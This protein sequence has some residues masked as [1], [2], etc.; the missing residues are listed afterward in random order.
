[1]YYNIDELNQL[2]TSIEN[3]SNE[4]F[5]EIFEY[6]DGLD[7]YLA[8]SNLNSR[9][10]QLVTSSSIRFKINLDYETSKEIFLTNYNQIKQQ[11][12]SI[13][14]QLPININQL[15]PSFTI[16]SS[17]NRLESIVIED[18]LPDK[19]ILFLSHLADLPRLFS[20]NIKTIHIIEDLNNIY[21]LIFALPT[22]KYNKLYLY[23]NECSISIP[24]NNNK[25]LS[26]IEYLDI[27]HWYTFD[28]LSALISYTPQLRRLSLSHI[29]QDDSNTETMLPVTLNN[30]TYFSM[31]TNNINFDEFEMFIENI[32]SKLKVL[33]VSFSYKDITLLHA[34]RWEQLISRYFPQLEKFSLRYREGGG[35]R[36]EYPIYSGGQ[37][38]FISP[39][40]IERKWLLEIDTYEYSINYIVRPYRYF[41][42]DC[43]IC[44][45]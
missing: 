26:T 23:G 13:N 4:L 9:F 45:E 31:H 22:L 36:D 24:M 43:F 25:Q 28:E 21:Q 32:Y 3:F 15:L 38:Q 7:I 29:N 20:L 37:N 14:F 5:Y 2:L 44:I 10:E 1:L 41:G 16:D 11:I 27:A 33:R 17:F 40:W 8:F 12:Y 30:L 39:F 34:N 19:L 6:L 35:Y 18:I 42:K